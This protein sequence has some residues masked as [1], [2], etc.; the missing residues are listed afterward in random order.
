MGSTSQRQK[1]IK[2]INIEMEE[3]KLSLFPDDM[4]LYK[5]NLKVLTQKPLALINEFSKAAGHKINIT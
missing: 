4:I 5:K 2:S 1:E 3:V